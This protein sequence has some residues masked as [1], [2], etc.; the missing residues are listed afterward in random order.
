MSDYD[1]VIVGAGIAGLTAG[2]TAGR[3]GLSVA[4]IDQMGSGGQVLNVEKIENLP[5]F[6]Q[7]VA[8]YDLGAMV[9]SRRRRRAPP[10]SSTRRRAWRART[11][12]GSCAAPRASCAPRR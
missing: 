1:V 4:I 12:S 8:G 2:L 9:R 7:G 6:P 11:T 5:G 3:Y 10:S